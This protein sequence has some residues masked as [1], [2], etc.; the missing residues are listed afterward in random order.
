[1][2]EEVGRQQFRTLVRGYPVSFQMPWEDILQD[3]MKNCADKDLEE[4][5][6]PQE[7]LKYILRLHLHIDQLDMN[8]YLKQVHVRPFVLLLLLYALIDSGH[9]VF[10]G[11]GSVDTLKSRMRAAVEKEYPE[12]EADVPQEQRK[13][14]IPAAI[15]DVLKD[16]EDN[17]KKSGRA[18]RTAWQMHLNEKMQCQEM[19]LDLWKNALKMCVPW[20][21]H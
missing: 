21:S 13:G 6:R 1:M 5:P 18:N 15:L 12:T 11:K 10:R 7:C 3:L 2:T 8:K 19:N 20:P 9:E 14:A 16:T 17:T 4:I